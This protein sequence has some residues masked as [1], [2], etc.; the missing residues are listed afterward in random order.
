MLSNTGQSGLAPCKDRGQKETSDPPPDPDF[1][2][3][4]VCLDLKVW[5]GLFSAANSIQCEMYS[6]PESANALQ[7]W[8]VSFPSVIYTKLFKNTG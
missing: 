8:V 1:S 4:Q 6:M 2:K 3:T 5:L 7:T